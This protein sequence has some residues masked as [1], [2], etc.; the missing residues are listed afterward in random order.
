M[1]SSRTSC[2]AHLKPQ[3]FSFHNTPHAIRYPPL[4]KRRIGAKLSKLAEIE[5]TITGL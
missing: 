4:A 5:Q 3:P 1:I 2:I